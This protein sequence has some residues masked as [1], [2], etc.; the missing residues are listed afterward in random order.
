[1][2]GKDKLPVKMYR[3]QTDSILTRFGRIQFKNSWGKAI[4]RADCKTSLKA[5]LHGNAIFSAYY[6][7][8]FVPLTELAQ[9]LQNLLNQWVKSRTGSFLYYQSSNDSTWYF[10]Q[11]VTVFVFH[12]ESQS[13]F[14]ESNWYWNGCHNWRQN[15][16][17][18]IIMICVLYF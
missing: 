14:A 3:K 17:T 11:R 10:T 1:M 6:H 13:L 5:K 16:G 15:R 2:L 8:D 9:V 7:T 18:I 4:Q 12:P